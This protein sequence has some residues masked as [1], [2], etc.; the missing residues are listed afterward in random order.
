MPLSEVL[1]LIWLKQTPVAQG[2]V[3]SLV[4]LHLEAAAGP[5]GGVVL[6]WLQGA[7]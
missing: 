2:G 5:P 6:G 7:G 1:Y 4:D 3:L